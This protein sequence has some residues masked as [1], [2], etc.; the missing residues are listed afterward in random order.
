[1]TS[2]FNYVGYWRYYYRGGQLH[3][4]Q[5]ILL[6]GWP[7]TLV[8]RDI[9][10]GVASHT[11]CGRYLQGWPVTLVAGDIITGVASHTCCGRYYYRGGQSHLL[12]EILL[13][14]WPVKLVAGA[15]IFGDKLGK[16]RA[17]IRPDKQCTYN[18]ALRRLR[19]TIIAVEKEKLLH[20]LTAS[21]SS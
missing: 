5:E 21:F 10:S 18:V 19:A 7:V 17:L 20:I 16:D 1:M 14:G 13:Q 11:C 15:A 9:I 3:L 8:E 2:L 6:Q 4:L 12:R